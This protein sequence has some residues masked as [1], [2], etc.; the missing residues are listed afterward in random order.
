MLP[1]LV[2]EAQGRAEAVQCAAGQLQQLGGPAAQLGLFGHDAEAHRR[3]HGHAGPHALE[4]HP[5][6]HRDP[7]FT[8]EF[9]R[10]MPRAAP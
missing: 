1:L 8:C 10:S 5:F 2:S 9:N 3:S 4:K 7:S 6:A